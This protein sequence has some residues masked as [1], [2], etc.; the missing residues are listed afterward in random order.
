MH[1]LGSRVA[2]QQPRPNVRQD[3]CEGGKNERTMGDRV[4]IRER[5]RKRKKARK[6]ERVGDV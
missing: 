6:R 3:E 2:T 1:I 5:K 4:K